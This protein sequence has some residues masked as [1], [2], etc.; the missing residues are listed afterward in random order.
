MKKH[1]NL[2]KPSDISGPY[3]RIA[4][5]QEQALKL[6][7][8]FQ[9]SED[10][11]TEGA[12]EFYSTTSISHFLNSYYN[13]FPAIDRHCYEIVSPTCFYM[14]FDLDCKIASSTDSNTPNDIVNE[15]NLFYW[16]DAIYR[17]FIDC[18]INLFH[19]LDISK[20]TMVQPE[21]QL[22][23][24]VKADF[25]FLRPNWVVT[26][27]SNKN[28]LSLH[29]I[30]RNVGFD[31]IHIF[32][33]FYKEFRSFI[34][35]FVPEDCPFKGS[36]DVSVATKNRSMRLNGS[37]KMGSDRILKPFAEVHPKGIKQ[38]STFINDLI[39][40]PQ[41]DKKIFSKRLSDTLFANHDKDGVA[42]PAK[43]TKH[44]ITSFDS[45]NSENPD[46]LQQVKELLDML[47]DYRSTEYQ[48]WLNIAFIFKTH[49]LPYSLFEEF[50]KR[51]PS[52]DALR[53]REGFDAI[54]LK[55]LDKPLTI[56]TLH[57]Y[58]HEDNP[59][60]YR[61]FKAQYQNVA[62]DIPFTADQTISHR[63]I[64]KDLYLNGFSSH[65]IIALKSCMMT[66]KTHSLPAVFDAT[67]I[68]ANT[69]VIVY[70]RVSLTKEI[71][72]KFKDHRFEFYQDIK[73]PID[74]TKHSRVIIQA[75]SMHRLIGKADFLVLDEIE[76]TVA[77]LCSSTYLDHQRC[78]NALRNYIKR[79][80]KI[81][82]ADAN[83][84][85][86]T[87][88]VLLERRLDQCL[89][90]VNTQP[91]FV[92]LKAKMT[93]KKEELVNSILT[94]IKDGKR[95][96]IPTNSK[97]F[98]KKIE[99]VIRMTFPDKKVLCINSEGGNTKAENW[100]QYDALIYTPTIV[101][102]ISFDEKHFHAC[103]AYFINRSSNAE[104]SSQMLFRVRHL[105]DQ[106]LFIYCP[107]N[108]PGNPNLP[109]TNADIYK[110]VN[111]LIRSGHLH[112]NDVGLDIDHYNSRVE[113]NQYYKLYSS[114]LRKRHLSSLYFETYLAY[115][116]KYHGIRVSKD[117][118]KDTTNASLTDEEKYNI[119]NELGDAANLIKEKEINDLITVT[120]IRQ[121]EYRDLLDNRKE[122][123]AEE[124][125][126]I[127][128]YIL[129]NSFDLKWNTNLTDHKEW[130]TQNREHANGYARVKEFLGKDIDWILQQAK[131]RHQENYDIQLIE[132]ASQYKEE[133]FSSDSEDEEDKS[134]YILDTD[135]NELVSW[136]QALQVLR[137]RDVKS[138][139]VHSIHYNKKWL[140]LKICMEFLKAAGFKKLEAGAE[141]VKL[142]WE[143]LH[144]YC[145]ENEQH[146]RALFDCKRMEWKE[147]LDGKEKQ[148]LNQYITKKLEKEMA[149]K[150]RCDNGRKIY[151]HIE[152]L[153]NNFESQ[154]E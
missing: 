75:D 145:K 137:K 110:H 95:V 42:V 74:L 124:Q 77:H 126:Q 90:V 48:W 43:D 134:R 61:E 91:S 128:K 45:V 109:V 16:F 97:K 150:F 62:L 84:S 31:D 108:Y 41:R 118:A 32:K 68:K 30:N 114:F 140:K 98:S 47:K 127:K 79:T 132:K 10:T 73:G 3:T 112:A 141:K 120:P 70:F 64:S 24:L 99:M 51:A 93:N 35:S 69:I 67:H 81:L 138:T 135:K 148:S 72:I 39:N 46:H 106:Q 115:I 88:N 71:L 101:A 53:C 83:L 131:K 96:V 86:E 82:M 26:S 28:K 6:G 34:T 17:E 133:G 103:C 153:F 105:L 33:L 154:D 76:S 58:A 102:G 119:R 21:G 52:F 129:L 139:V 59:D 11:D 13:L 87:V 36:F 123:T 14:Y 92:G 63:F 1:S 18:K 12:K 125:L 142:N 23:P 65:N 57:Y 100:I 147:T 40:D 49:K 111:E 5:M 27:A 7:H 143:E 85:D 113:K 29:L 2:A 54:T 117:A 89:K 151:Y 94:L 56:G 144:S 25:N 130:I 78:Y 121:L 116:L 19:N 9:W 20:T 50:S 80:P 149:L 104:M 146:I 66:G 44:T 55:Q 8:T 38:E 22:T 107:K 37:C 4:R 122:K 136:R 152:Y 60:K 15:T